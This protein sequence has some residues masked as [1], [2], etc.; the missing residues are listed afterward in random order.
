MKD[1]IRLKLDG[2][3]DRNFG[4]D[5]MQKTVV[6]YLS[7]FRFYADDPNISPLVT[8]EK[9]VAR[10]KAPHDVSCLSVTGSGFMIN[11][12]HAL[13]MEIQS[14][15]SGKRKEDYCIGC[16][17][18][19]IRYKLGRSLMWNRLRRFRYISCR[20]K[21]SYSVLKRHVKCEVRYFPDLLFALPERLI[22]PKTNE[23]LLGIVMM[24]RKEDSD[25]CDYYRVMAKAADF[26]C[27]KSGKAVL[28]FAFDSGEENDLYACLCVL[29]KMKYKEKA[30]IISHGID[31]EILNAYSRCSKIITARFHGAVVALKT[32]TD[33]YPILY[34]E[35]M[36]NLLSDVEYPLKGSPIDSPNEDDI[37]RFLFRQ[38][39]YTLTDETERQAAE[40]LSA[41]H[42][43]ILKYESR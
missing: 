6:S 34:R 25:D 37:L 14:F 35:K 19:P 40:S 1:K 18:E 31:N 23:E 8:D 9:N 36:E 15:L 21:K 26:W 41:L 2:Y 17:L 13:R 43:A 4:D 39:D 29:N 10:Q 3:F 16:N 11:S 22:P 27:E 30:L 24:R 12:R 20:D 7:D 28:L 38:N 32:R 33:F 42:D 5:Y